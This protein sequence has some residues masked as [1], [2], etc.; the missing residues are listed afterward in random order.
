M[1]QVQ[2]PSGL[3]IG[4]LEGKPM[5]G[6]SEACRAHALRCFKVAEKACTPEERRE[7]L[8]FAESWERLADEIERNERLITLIDELAINNP[9]DE[10]SQRELYE[11]TECQR[12]STRSLRR[13]AAAIV[14]IS[15]HF[16]TEANEVEQVLGTRAD[17]AAS[18]QL[19]V[20]LKS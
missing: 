13:L 19:A 16:A 2:P 3:G 6:H 12:P 18:L 5:P 14:S 8:S 9:I 15:D 20:A 4:H 1:E 7:F 17:E 10:D 11:P